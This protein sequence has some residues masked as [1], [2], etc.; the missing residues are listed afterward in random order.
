M[1]K[2]YASF[3]QENYLFFVLEYIQGGDF[4]TI[5][6]DYTCLDETYAK[7]YIAE[8]VLAISYLHDNNI[9]HRDLKPENVL[10]D[11]DG[12]IKLVD[13]GLSETHLENMIK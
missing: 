10:I 2:A 11:K 8:M 13:F 4:S 1:A 5:L 6:K 7:F 9:I 3:A 12:H